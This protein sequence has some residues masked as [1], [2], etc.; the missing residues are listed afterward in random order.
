MYIMEDFFFNKDNMTHSMLKREVNA[1]ESRKRM[2]VSNN[3]LPFVPKDSSILE[4]FLVPRQVGVPT[5]DEIPTSS[6]LG[7]GLDGIDE[8]FMKK[9]RE[10][11]FLEYCG[12][13]VRK[14]K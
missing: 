4:A 2:T 11:G 14:R 6:E 1:Q 7:L 9:V 3:I 13:V 5:F 12:V 8:G 10:S